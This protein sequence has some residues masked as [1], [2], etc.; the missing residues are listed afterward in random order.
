MRLLCRF[1]LFAVLSSAVTVGAATSNYYVSPTGNDTTGDG[2]QARPWKTIQKAADTMSAGDTC[3]V[4][5]GEYAELVRPARSGA[6]GQ[7]ISFVADGSAASVVGT[8]RITGWTAHSGSVWK[9]NVTSDFDDLFVDRQRMVIARWPNLTTGDVYRPNFFQATANGGDTSIIDANHLTQASGYWDGAKIFMV[10]GLG[11]VADQRSV[12]GYDPATHRITFSPAISN[13]EW[14]DADQYSLYFL[15]DKLALLDAPSEWFLDRTTHTVYVWLPDGSDPNAHL[16]ES[17]GGSAGFD[18]SG[19]SYV[20]VSGV[21]VINGN[22]SLVNATWCRIESV[23]HLYPTIELKMSGS[24]NVITQ[25]EI[26][27]AGYTGVRIAGT[28]NTV[29]RCH[30]HHCDYLGATTAEYF[31]FDSLIQ[32]GFKE[33]WPRIGESHN[34]VADCSLHD[35]GRDGVIAQSDISACVLEHNEIYNTGLIALDTGG[36]YMSTMDGGGTVLRYNI[37]HD[38]RPRELYQW[39]APVSPGNGIYLDEASANFVVHHNL[40]YGVPSQGITLHQASRN[41]LVYNNTAVGSG[42]GWGDII[43][44]TPGGRWFGVEGTEVANNLAVILDGRAG[45][46]NSVP[47]CINFQSEIPQ[48][49][50]NGYYN[51]LDSQKLHSQGL[52]PTAVVGNPL[53]TNAAANDFSLQAGSPMIDKGVVI[54]G[55]TD[56]YGGAAP[57][58]GAYERGSSEVPGLRYAVGPPA[59]APKDHYVSPSGNDTTGDGSQ[60]RPWK[61]IQRAADA[62]APGDTCHVQDGDYPEMIKPARSGTISQYL[63]FVADGASVTLAGT[64]AITGWTVHNGNIWKATVTTDFADLFVDRQ[65]MVVARWPNLAS[66]DAYRPTF[67]QAT[68]NG[69][70]T[71]IIDATHFS[72]PSGY[73][74]GARIFMVPGLGWVADQRTVTGYDPGA[75]QL[76]FSPAISYADYYDADQYTQIFPVRQAFAAGCAVR[77]VP[78]PDDAHGV[79]VAA[80]WVRSEHA[81]CR[82]VRRARGFRPHESV[83]CPD[84]GVQDPQRR[85]QAA[86]GDRLRGGERVAPLSDGR[87]AGERVG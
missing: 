10:P 68:A 6:A 86:A 79:R 26:A 12:T 35:A 84:D 3:H 57:D 48:Y 2:S 24:D 15:Y 81:P 17:S 43:N 51:P 27:Y 82:G 73:W 13:A 50:Y 42:G 54:P 34:T 7:Y 49:R 28:R 19:R 74:D 83:V 77:V 14:Y 21:S 76:T 80:G 4:L 25:S 46:D 69:G 23:R 30:I 33:V 9:A 29:S 67:Y 87:V 75:H 36:F 32:F 72:Q 61:T 52:E 16:V 8:R 20:R 55:I 41:N 39:G 5:D 37:V 62:M 58:I 22:I 18:L 78:G 38:I 11:W 70:D 45:L 63:S 56:G 71:S 31:G 64:R 60:G 47:W 66:G 1:V 53:F 85:H 44:S 40:V 65:R 59:P